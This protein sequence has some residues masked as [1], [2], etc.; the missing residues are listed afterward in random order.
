METHKPQRG[1]FLAIVLAVALLLPVG[2]V[3]SIG[4]A[5]GLY[6]RDYVSPAAYGAYCWPAS[7]VAA[8]CPPFAQALS[9]YRDLFGIPLE[10]DLP[11]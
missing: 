11:Q 2:Y 7:C 5:W 1:G 6:V 3:L 10:I 4:P 9:K 8:N